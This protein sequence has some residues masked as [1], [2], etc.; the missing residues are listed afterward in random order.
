MCTIHKSGV[1]KYKLMMC[2]IHKSGVYKLMMCTIHKSDVYKLMMCTIHKS[3]VYGFTGCYVS[4]DGN[5]G[6]R[7]NPIISLGYRSQFVSYNNTHSETKF[8]T[9][10]VP[11]GFVLGPLLF[12]LYIND[13]LNISSKVIFFLFTDDTNIFFEY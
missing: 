7:L 3:G 11:Q 8:I 6:E 2:T 9:C 10:G 5:Q 1:Y 4:Q 13:F 12:L